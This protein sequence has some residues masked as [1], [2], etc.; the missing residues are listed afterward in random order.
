M[1]AT[2]AM[3][4]N[5]RLSTPASCHARLSNVQSNKS[6]AS[7]FYPRDG[8]LNELWAGS[9]SHVD[10]QR[11]LKDRRSPP[12]PGCNSLSR[13]YFYAAWHGRPRRRHDIESGSYPWQGPIPKLVRSGVFHLRL[14]MQPAEN[15]GAFWPPP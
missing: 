7:S 9:I 6:K 8:S 15:R 12:A 5:G 10:L 4:P 1:A 14:A 3:K 11:T 2:M 13:Q